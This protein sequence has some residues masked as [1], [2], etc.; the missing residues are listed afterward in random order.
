MTQ[1]TAEKILSYL[2]LNSYNNII[3]RIIL[4]RFID[5]LKYVNVNKMIYIASENQK[6]IEECIEMEKETIEKIKKEFPSL[7]RDIVLDELLNGLN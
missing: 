5:Y 7:Y 2:E 6:A 1:L 4:Y 3:N